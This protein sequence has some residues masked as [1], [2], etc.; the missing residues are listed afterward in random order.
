MFSTVFSLW[1]RDKRHFVGNRANF[2]DSF[3]WRIGSGLLYSSLDE[4]HAR[5]TAPSHTVTPKSC[6]EVHMGNLPVDRP[7][8]RLIITILHLYRLP[9]IIKPKYPLLS[10]YLSLA[11][12]FF[13]AFLFCNLLP[14][15]Y[16]Y[17]SMNMCI[18]LYVFDNMYVHKKLYDELLW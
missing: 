3:I 16:L 8:A 15:S 17:K 10:F 11:L 6:R 18:Y 12:S 2:E 4:G 14:R 7:N 5:K 1:K 13:R 9:G